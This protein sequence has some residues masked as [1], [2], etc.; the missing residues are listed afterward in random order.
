MSRGPCPQAPLGYVPAS[1]AVKEDTSKRK[2]L[3]KASVVLN[4]FVACLR[5]YERQMEFESVKF[6]DGSLGQ[7]ARLGK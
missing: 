7:C 2:L 1:S 4:L 5:N 6:D 3:R